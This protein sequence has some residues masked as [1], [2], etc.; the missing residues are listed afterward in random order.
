MVEPSGLS[1]ESRAWLTKLA[2]RD[3]RTADLSAVDLTA[4]SRAEIDGLMASLKR[5]GY[6]GTEQDLVRAILT[7]TRDGVGRPEAKTFQAFSF[8]TGTVDSVAFV[9]GPAGRPAAKQ[10]ASDVRDRVLRAETV[11]DGA[12]FHTNTYD[13]AFLNRDSRINAA[14]DARKALAT[15]FGFAPANPFDLTAVAASRPHIPR[16]RIPEFL[17]L[18]MTAHFEH[19]GGG[20]AWH[21]FMASDGVSQAMLFGTI[22]HTDQL[23]DGRRVVDCQ[24]F[25]RIGEILLDTLIPGRD[26]GNVFY[27]S[28]RVPGHEMALL[29]DGA[30]LYV[31]DNNKVEKLPAS[32]DELAYLKSVVEVSSWMPTLLPLDNVDIPRET[33]PCLYDYVN[34]KHP[35]LTGTLSWD[36]GDAL[37][38][39]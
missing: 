36:D 15:E 9:D 12:L 2:G 38:D 24:G 26:Q 28:I 4:A 7:L 27:K 37:V 39:G 22:S 20:T 19:P 25:S 29:R 6:N 21:G 17:H 14:L 34:A 32:D 35:T 11:A 10:T 1:G 16:S 18:Y 33:L 8:D 31:I 3:G 23:P 13:S 5:D 30:S